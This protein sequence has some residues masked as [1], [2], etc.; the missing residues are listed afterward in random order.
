VLRTQLIGLL[1][2]IHNPDPQNSSGSKVDH[3]RIG[4]TAIS[5]EDNLGAHLSL[6]P[7]YQ[8]PGPQHSEKKL[9][10]LTDKDNFISDI[11]KIKLDRPRFKHGA[12]PLRMLDEARYL[13][14]DSTTRHYTYRIL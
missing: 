11:I 13:D 1:L 7:A 14:F 12:M 9:L 2:R 5:L 10:D 3:Q 8:I 4:F 6:L